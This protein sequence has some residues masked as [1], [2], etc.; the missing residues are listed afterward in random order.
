VPRQSFAGDQKFPSSEHRNGFEAWRLLCKEFNSAGS[1]RRIAILKAVLHFNFQGDYLDKFN[2]FTDLVQQYDRL[3][4]TDEWGESVKLAI[5]VEQAP[6]QLRDHLN[7]NANVIS[8]FSQSVEAIYAYFS[9]KK[10][11][12]VDGLTPDKYDKGGV[13]PMDVDGLGKGKDKGKKGDKGGKGKDDYKGGYKGQE[14]K[15]GKDSY[16][17]GYKG[18]Q[19]SYQGA[20][21]GKK[22]KCSSFKAIATSVAVGAIVPATVGGIRRMVRA[23][24]QSTSW[25]LKRNLGSITCHHR[26]RQGPRQ[27][28][29][30]QHIRREHRLDDGIE[31]GGSESDR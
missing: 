14:S 31:R 28:R 20:R 29:S 5:V 13:A 30:N 24:S 19:S 26:Q 21:K 11:H 1:G 10:A 3:D 2:I 6:K 17:G 9:N 18:D 7:L 27:R 8:G 16:K 23:A 25:A 15:G 12:V 4:I 22:G